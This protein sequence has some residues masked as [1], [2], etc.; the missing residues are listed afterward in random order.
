MGSKK[1]ICVIPARYQSTRFPGKPL[2]EI[3]GKSMIQRV[4]EQVLKAELIDDVYIATDDI[5]IKNKAESFGAKVVMTSKHH[6]CGTDR[7]AEAVQ[8]I[9][10]DIIINV[11]GD[12]P[13]IEPAALDSVIK[14]MLDDPTLQMATLITPIVDKKEYLNP[15]VAK[16]T[17]DKDN[18]ILYCS[19]S[20][21]PYSRDGDETTIF[22][23]IGVYVYKRDFLIAFSK[24]DQTP[25]EIVEKL[26]QLRALENGYKIKAVETNYQPIGVDVPE[27][28]KKVEEILKIKGECLTCRRGEKR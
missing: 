20:L 8:T 17:K 1:V 16:V 2:V 22:K 3:C 6:K 26:E 7:I 28:V 5:R 25:Y 10:G 27:D 19:R 4:Y 12:E 24:M 21:I 14:T 23:Q 11:Q 9:E 18:F 13:L 15:N